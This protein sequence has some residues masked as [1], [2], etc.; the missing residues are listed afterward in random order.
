MSGIEIP[1]LIGATAVGTATSV[2]GQQMAGRE[3]DAS[4][5][6]EAD[7]LDRQAKA[8]REAAG[9]DEAARRRDLESSL[10]TIQVMRAG[11]G[12]SLDSPTGQAIV[13]GVVTA[14]E[15]DIGI[16]KA[17]YLAKADNMELAAEQTRRK[18]HASL[19]AADIG[20]LTTIASGVGKIATAG[21]YPMKA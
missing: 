2:Y 16:S 7:Q 8:T 15:R 18:G 12:L 11:R 19:L 1:L 5:R 14:G 3:S 4:A 13:G 6:F 21:R 17:N 20:S 9:Q 10:E